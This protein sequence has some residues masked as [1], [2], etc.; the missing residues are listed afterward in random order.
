MAQTSGSEAV[1]IRHI[2]ISAK[3]L[4]INADD[5][6]DIHSSKIISATFK[7]KGPEPLNSEKRLDRGIIIFDKTKYTIKEI[8]VTSTSFSANIYDKNLLIGSISLTFVDTPD[9]IVWAGKATIK[10]VKYNAY[11][12]Q[13]SMV[14][15]P[16]KQLN[17]VQEYCDNNPNAEGCSKVRN[18]EQNPSSEGCLPLWKEYCIKNVQDVRCKYYLKKL[19]EENP[20]LEFCV[21]Q[22]DSK[23]ETFFTARTEAK[24]GLSARLNDCKK[25]KLDC[26]KKCIPT[27]KDTYT[28]LSA[29]ERDCLQKCIKECEPCYVTGM[30]IP[31]SGFEGDQTPVLEEGS[32]RLCTPPYK[33][34]EKNEATEKGCTVVENTIVADQK[35]ICSAGLVCAK[36]PTKVTCPK[37]PPIDSVSCKVGKVVPKFDKNKCIVGYECLVPKGCIC[38]AIYDPVCGKDGKTYSNSC[39]A[40]CAGVEIAYKGRC[41][42]KQDGEKGSECV[43]T[44]KVCNEYG[45]YE[46]FYKTEDCP[47]V[48]E[49]QPKPTQGPGHELFKTPTPGYPI[50]RPTASPI[51]TPIPTISPK[52][53][54][55]WVYPIP[56]VTTNPSPECNYFYWFDNNN[57]TC[58]Y[59]KFCGFYMYEGLRTFTTLK[60]CEQA[61]CSPYQCVAKS[62]AER[63]KC[64]LKSQVPCSYTNTKEE[65]YCY[66][67][68][69]VI[70]G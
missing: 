56:T 61:L 15:I 46:Y 31:F 20:A 65:K 2:H 64:T 17:Q 36:C 59:K 32:Y 7:P 25:C 52:P 12:L 50:P 63:Y 3:G 34:M 22:T 35:Y 58:G 16:F 55:T 47:D 6:M 29:D 23:D 28:Q 13:Y 24:D 26:W 40:E 69:Y 68:G 54:P 41:G 19:C 39:E 49:V 37:A 43:I 38:V 9:V 48:P 57:R 62:V 5:S 70:Q 67:C 53:T 66:S 4:L 10:E 1:D 42:S 11:Y 45:C 27:K 30:P 21:V 60:E 14:F 51:K 44:K 8:V 18:C 33:C